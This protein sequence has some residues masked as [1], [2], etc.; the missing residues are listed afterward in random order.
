MAKAKSIFLIDTAGAD[1]FGIYNDRAFSEI[2]KLT[3]NDGTVISAD[4][5][6]RGPEKYADVEIVFS[7]WGAPQMDEELLAA[8]PNLKAFFYGAGSVRHLLTDAFWERDILLTSAYQSN[9]VPVAEYTVSSIVFALKQA[10][11][12]AQRLRAGVDCQSKVAML[13]AYH[14]SR[15]GIVSL[16]AI[17]R[18]VCEKLARM[19][20]DVFAYDPFASDKI[21]SDYNVTRVDSLEALFLSCHV[22]S[23]HAP[24]LPQTEGLIT[25]DLLRS[26]PEG[27][28]FI[29]TSRGAIVDEAAMVEVL[30]E[31][32][33]LFAVID[34]ITDEKDY[35]AAPI[36]R[37][38]NVFLTPHLAGSVGNECHRMGASAV[39]ECR[40][41][42]TGEPPI[43]PISQE[44]A[45]TL[46]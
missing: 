12:Q 22:V 34:V 41:Y 40:R 44:I 20:L 2:K 39:E 31:R 14:G 25:G 19:E 3:D 7:G 26:M 38:P 43:T 15:V 29:N 16:G 9:A 30:K 37:L 23:L 33:D 36:A 21:F 17:G 5:V 32:E 18:L 6:L 1:F 4:A 11:R 46:A 10:W 13:G 42:L 28:T 35:S 8:L 45:K 27:A 24:W